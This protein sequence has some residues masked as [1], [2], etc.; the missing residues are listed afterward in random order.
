MLVEGKG[1]RVYWRNCWLK[2]YRKGQSEPIEE[3]P[4]RCDGQGTVSA[5]LEIAF[6][7]SGGIIKQI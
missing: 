4:E 7:G 1:Q 3:H 6:S 2:V 5:D